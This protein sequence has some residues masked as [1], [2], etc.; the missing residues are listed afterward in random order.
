MSEKL[1]RFEYIQQR[2]RKNSDDISA[3]IERGFY[4]VDEECDHEARAALN[5][6]LELDPNNV[7]A[8]FWKAE[9]WFYNF[10]HTSG[11]AEPFLLK[12]LAI[13]PTRADCYLSL[14][15]TTTDMN[16]KIEY[17]EEAVAL[18]PSWP[19]PRRV[20]ISNLIELKLF[21]RA[22]ELLHDGFKQAQ[23]FKPL[24]C[25]STDM[26]AYYEAH[27]TG[28]IFPQDRSPNSGMSDFEFL[29]NALSKARTN[30]AINRK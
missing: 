23:K 13:D 4:G 22:E 6:A 17:L 11:S 19:L 10:G 21:D 14:S 12:A 29:R 26:K 9:N 3:L 24:P 1:N 28:R 27:V 16:K 2:L 30:L 15:K 18:E 20:L 7:D 25:P 5:Y 8:L